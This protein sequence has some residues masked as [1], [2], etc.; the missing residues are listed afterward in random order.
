MTMT[1]RHLHLAGEL[2]EGTLC[3]VMHTLEAASTGASK[4]PVVAGCCPRYAP[5]L[6]CMNVRIVRKQT[7]KAPCGLTQPVKSDADDHD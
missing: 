7:I 5:N 3:K 2:G 6:I 1:W 4:R